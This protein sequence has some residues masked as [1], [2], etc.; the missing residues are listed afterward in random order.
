[1]YSYKCQLLYLFPK[2][3]VLIEPLK[4]FYASE[5]E[6]FYLS[7]AIE[8]RGELFKKRMAAIVYKSMKE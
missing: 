8:I 1:M 3:G 6:I 4:K 2:S 7:V 5:D